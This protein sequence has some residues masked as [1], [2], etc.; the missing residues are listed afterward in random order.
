M[1][2]GG[3]EAVE[4][5]GRLRGKVFGLLAGALFGRFFVMY[6]TLHFAE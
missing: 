5:G 4:M 2:G 3:A 6:V 1:I